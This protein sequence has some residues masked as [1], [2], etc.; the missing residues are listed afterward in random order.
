MNAQKGS[1]FFKMATT[2][3]LTVVFLMLLIHFLNELFN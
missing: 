1:L 3:L 2:I